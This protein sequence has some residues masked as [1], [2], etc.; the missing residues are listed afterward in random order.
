MAQQAHSVLSVRINTKGDK[1]LSLSAEERAE[2]LREIE[3]SAV[4]WLPEIDKKD[5]A[6]KLGHEH[7]LALET[8]ILIFTGVSLLIGRP[9]IDGFLSEA[10]KDL[11]KSIKRLTA[12]IWKKQSDRAYTLKGRANVIFELGDDFVAVEFKT[13]MIDKGEASVS[14]LETRFQDNLANLSQ[15][16]DQIVAE[17]KELKE[18]HPQGKGAVYWVRLIGQG[19]SIVRLP[20]WQTIGG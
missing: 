19:R 6:I 9:V 18:A 10:G 4:V 12:L 1:D 3:D 13:P 7:H 20:S 16:W 8:Y 17:V 14:G 11:W 5:F 15:Q 2:I